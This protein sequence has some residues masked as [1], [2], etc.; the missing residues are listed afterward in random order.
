VLGHGTIVGM[1]PDPYAVFT[2]RLA[3]PGVVEICVL[4]SHFGF[5]AY[6]GGALEERTDTIAAAAADASG[7]SLYAVLHPPP[8]PEHL[9]SILVRPAESPTLAAFID[10]VD[11]VVTIHG[12]GRWG[13]FTSLLL[14]GRN[15][16]LATTIGERLGERLDGYEI[17]TELEA[18]PRE[19]RGM[20][21]DNPVNLPRLAGVQIELPPR[22]RGLG[23]KWADW[24]GDGFVPPAQALVDVLAS[25]AAGWPPDERDPTA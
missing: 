3:E 9:P 22:V 1:A 19:L 2:R 4:R 13:M 15:R 7:A 23:P 17:V 20:H 21:P 11:V 14:G 18:I 16:E 6:H 25:V 5:M 8:D 24:R 10:H 12:Y